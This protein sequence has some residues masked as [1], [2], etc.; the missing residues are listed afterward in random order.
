MKI[1][2]LGGFL[3]SGKTSILLPLLRRLA[4]KE[5]GGNPRKVAVIENEIGE[6]SID[7]PALKQSGA[8]VTDML[9][10]CICCSLSG[11]LIS[12]IIDIQKTY[13]PEWLVIEMTG[14]AYP[15][16]AVA[17]IK[18]YLPSA[19][20]KTVVIVDA[21]RW[22]ELV[23]LM[24]PLMK[25]QLSGADTIVLNKMDQVSAGQGKAIAGDLRR[26]NPR[27]AVLPASALQDLD[28]AVLESMLPG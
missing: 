22:E 17:L 15:G 7:G 3:G 27:A 13:D 28:A 25:G 9:A 18:E 8:L 23:D 19:P 21:C 1:I 6:V 26:L 10:G 11:D 24:E 5:G 16:K 12:G 4:A 20:V 14:L 2:V